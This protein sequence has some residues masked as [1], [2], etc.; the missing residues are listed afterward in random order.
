[1]DELTS[2]AAASP[3]LAFSSPLDLIRLLEG[4]RVED[5]LLVCRMR[6][7]I[8]TIIAQQDRHPAA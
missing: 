3:G 2:A 8:I 4:Q 7:L 6:S 5:R 1:M